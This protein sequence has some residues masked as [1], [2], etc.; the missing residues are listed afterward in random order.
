MALHTES[1]TLLLKPLLPALC[2]LCVPPA[3]RALLLPI[4]LLHLRLLVHGAWP[5]DG[6]CC[7]VLCCV[8]LRCAALGCVVLC[9]V[10]VLCVV[11][12]CVGL[13]VVW[14]AKGATTRQRP[15]CLPTGPGEWESCVC[16]AR[17]VRVCLPQRKAGVSTGPRCS[18]LWWQLRVLCGGG[19]RAPAP[20]VARRGGGL[21][22]SPWSVSGA[23]CTPCPP[24]LWSTHHRALGRIS[25]AA[26]LLWQGILQQQGILH[27]Q[28]ILLLSASLPR[29]SGQRP[30]CHTLPHR[31][32][33]TRSGTPSECCLTAQ[34]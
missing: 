7:V 5:N 11:L 19:A 18:A 23:S 33:A 6:Q 10:V 28:G 14:C 30:F 15:G 25:S 4:R 8:V 21:Q 22:P 34:G 12:P 9:C 31:L 27:S 29:G 24:P 13:C 2:L 20:V 17:A 16:C 1:C 26:L 3:P 32:G